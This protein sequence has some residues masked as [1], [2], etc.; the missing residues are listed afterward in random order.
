MYKC[1]DLEFDYKE[2]YII[3]FELKHD[4]EFAIARR[5]CGSVGCSWTFTNAALLKKHVH[6]HR[7]KFDHAKYISKLQKNGICIV[8][9]MPGNLG[10]ARKDVVARQLSKLY[11]APSMTIENV[12]AGIQ[13]SEDIANSRAMANMHNAMFDIL[14]TKEMS[15]EDLQTVAQSLYILSHP[16]TGFETEAKRMAW[17]KNKGTLVPFHQ[18][19]A[20]ECSFDIDHMLQTFLQQPGMLETVKKHMK[21]CEDTPNVNFRS[22][23]QGEL[24]K[25]KKALFPGKLVIPLTL[26]CGD[27]RAMNTEVK[28]GVVHVN[29]A[30]LPTEMQPML[31]FV[32]VAG[33]HYSAVRKQVSVDSYLGPTLELL[34]SLQDEGLTLDLGPTCPAEQVYFCLVNVQGADD[35]LDEILE[36]TSSDESCRFCTADQHQRRSM[37]TDADIFI[38]KVATESIFDEYHLHYQGTENWY[39]DVVTDFLKGVCKLDLGLIIL[40]NL[41]FVN[42]I[43]SVETLNHRM[44]RFRYSTDEK[45]NMPKPFLAKDLINGKIKMSAAQILCFVR[46]FP[47]MVG[48]LINLVEQLDSWKLFMSMRSVLETL[49]AETS[50]PRAA[51]NLQS[52]VELHHDLFKK[53]HAGILPAE[54]HNATHYWRIVQQLGLPALQEARP[55]VSSDHCFSCVNK[56]E[57]LGAIAWKHQMILNNKLLRKNYTVDDEFKAPELQSDVEFSILQDF[58]IFGPADQFK[59][60]LSVSCFKQIF[61]IGSVVVGGLNKEGRPEFCQIEHILVDSGSKG[62]FKLLCA[63]MKIEYGDDRLG[64]VRVSEIE[65]KIRQVVGKGDVMWRKCFN[66][67][68]INGN[69]YV[70]YSYERAYLHF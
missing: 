9:L 28:V 67:H 10:A 64:N 50:A 25:H 51:K 36:R 47:L 14:S 26:H 58:F 68:T 8:S 21:A 37:T 48:D 41:I 63:R 70:S 39:L 3:H 46:N 16:F 33:L 20:V 27:F 15:R 31:D 4:C 44:L 17:F 61:K 49:L 65:P 12:A 24:W 57:V 1:C 13:V 2:E 43:V 29:M 40:P 35:V 62:D 19:G 59:S 11:A 5:K 34:K 45:R 32:F 53:L 66:A 69:I 23:L 22:V 7:D 55:S 52:V 30:A 54:F 56:T 6:N 38:R 18:D 42:K 60:V